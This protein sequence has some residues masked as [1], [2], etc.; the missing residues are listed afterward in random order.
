[1]RDDKLSSAHDRS[2]A[3]KT[4]STSVYHEFVSYL[5]GNEDRGGENCGRQRL[6][7]SEEPSRRPFELETGLR[8]GESH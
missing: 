2:L 4:F 8:E 1:M 7:D 6:P 3:P 5:S